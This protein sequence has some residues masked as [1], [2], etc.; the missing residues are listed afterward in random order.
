MGW[1]L[2]SPQTISCVVRV[3][4]SDTEYQI[5]AKIDEAGIIQ[6]KGV[7][8]FNGKIA[9]DWRTGGYAWD[10]GEPDGEISVIGTV[11][12]LQASGSYLGNSGK[13]DYCV[14]N[15]VY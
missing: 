3:G 13:S 11:T 4:N 5:L 15:W 6:V 1:A 2:P 12:G 9:F 7:D 8:A 10:E 14:A